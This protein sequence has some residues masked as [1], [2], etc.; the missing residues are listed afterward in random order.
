MF[1]KILFTLVVSCC[2]IAEEPFSDISYQEAIEKSRTSNK[3][4]MIDFYT[5]WCGPCKMLDKTTWKDKK[6]QEWLEE[7]TIP[8]KI[9]AE[10]LKPIAQKFDIAAYPTI[11]FVNS[12]EKVVGMFVGYKSPENFIPAAV[13]AISGIT[14]SSIARKELAKDKNNPSLRMDLANKLKREK[15]YE[16]ALD[17]YTWCWEEALKHDPTFSGTRI[18]FLLMYVEQLSNKYPSALERLNSW[19]ENAKEVFESDNPTRQGCMDYF[20]LLRTNGTSEEGR[21]SIYDGLSERGDVGKEIQSWLG[22][23][24]EDEMFNQERFE[25]YLNIVNLDILIILLTTNEKPSKDGK[26]SEMIINMQINKS[27]MPFEALLVLKQDEKASRLLD[28]ILQCD[29]SDE[30]ID[31]LRSAAISRD[32]SDYI[33]LI[34]T[35]VENVQ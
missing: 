31:K 8:I 10:K 33:E 4:V 22:Y 17:L 7:K 15:K 19:L 2:V 26:Y 13:N 5:T 24:V 23:L 28:A 3:L 16:E 25:E 27:V 9:D 18:S 20:N 35:A 1:L 12:A 11:V 32:R 34:N 14:E 30:T 29:S 6:V 21:L